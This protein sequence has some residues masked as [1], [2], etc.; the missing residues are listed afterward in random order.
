MQTKGLKAW[1]TKLASHYMPVAGQVI[2]ELN[3]LTGSDD[4]TLHQLSEVI[5]RDPHL[6]SHVLR[7]ANSV[8]FNQHKATINTVSRAVTLIG[9]K[10]MRAISISVLLMDA[11][12][13]K[14]PK[15]RLLQV[16]AQGFHAANQAKNLVLRF[17]EHAA[18]EVFV[19][20]L[21]FNLGEMAFWSSEAMSDDKKDLLLADDKLRAAATERYLGTSFRAISLGLAKH[22]KL[23]DTLIEAL[24]PG[25]EVSTKAQI[26]IL[27]ERLAK[28]APKGWDSPD[29]QAVL[30]DMAQ[31][32][33]VDETVA[34]S[35]ALDAAEQA[36]EV[37]LRYGAASVCPLIPN[38]ELVMGG[39]LPK[40][41][42]GR[43][44]QADAQLQL[45]ILREL[46]AASSEALDVNTI[47]QMVLEGMHRGIGLERV[48]IAF[49]QHHR[50]KAKFA[51]GQG[52][53]DWRNCFDFDASP[54]GDNLFIQAITQGGCS[55]FD[56]HTPE[57]LWSNEVQRVL[58]CVPCLVFVLQVNGRKPALFYADRG[59]YGGKITQDHIDSFS[60]FATQAQTNL[61][62]TAPGK[63]QRAVTSAK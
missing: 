21:L 6:T 36:A 13:K 32:A 20:A 23:G 49:I 44:L 14:G 12:L 55:H 1:I 18:E 9:L 51:L 47:F 56:A 60:H 31:L 37:A 58:D 24:K 46:S 25:D 35:W 29:V 54:F 39:Q 63:P 28:A 3:A 22:W 27:G 7:V 11:L 2:A 62:K 59:G 17:D 8:Y 43:V 26:V 57:H 61:S 30:N 19:A 42:V 50:V 16:M 45:S 38:R 15:E 10:G 34:K 5:L 41:Q 52:T 48:A 4:S 53:D 33:G 40:T